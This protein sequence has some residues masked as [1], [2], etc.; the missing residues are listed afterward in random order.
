MPII[1]KCTV[2][3][4]HCVIQWG[5]TTDHFEMYGDTKSLCHTMGADLVL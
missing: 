4:N 2:I 3:S 5:L 1:F